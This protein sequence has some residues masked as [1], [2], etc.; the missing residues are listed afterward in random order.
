MKITANG[1]SMNYTLD[2]PA[3]APVATLSHSLAT[4]LSMWDP[5]MKALTAR[6]RVLRYDTR[7]HGGTEAPA[8]AYTLDQ[9]ADRTASRRLRRRAWSRSSKGRSRAGSP[10]HSANSTRTSWIP[11]AP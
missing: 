6:Y 10:R 8:A 11:S 2:G 1:I 3:S 4:D 5:Q 9:L 7:G